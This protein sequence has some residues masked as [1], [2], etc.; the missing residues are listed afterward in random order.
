MKLAD[1]GPYFL[2]I[3]VLFIVYELSL[4]LTLSVKANTATH[5]ENLTSSE[6]LRSYM[7]Y[8]TVYEIPLSLLNISTT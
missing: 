5:K 7:R 1:V 6:K 4:L 8:I 2:E 3:L